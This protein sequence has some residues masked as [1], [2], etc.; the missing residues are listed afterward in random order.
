MVVAVA[1][2]VTEAQLQS[3]VIGSSG[4]GCVVTVADDID[5][6]V[7]VLETPGHE[8]AFSSVYIKLNCRS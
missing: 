4:I 1:R 3:V 8:S 6:R 2:D 5:G 7:V